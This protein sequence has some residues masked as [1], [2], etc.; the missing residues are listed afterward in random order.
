MYP[1]QSFPERNNAIPC[2]YKGINFRS[3]LEARWAY[4]FDK[5]GWA[6]EY[7]P[8]EMD[9][10]I[11]DFLIFTGLDYFVD[12][13]PYFNEEYRKS[14]FEKVVNWNKSHNVEKCCFHDVIF[15]L[16]SPMSRQHIKEN[17]PMCDLFNLGHLNTSFSSVILVPE[18]IGNM[19]A[20]SC[21]YDRIDRTKWYCGELINA[22]GYNFDTVYR[23]PHD[24]LILKKDYDLFIEKLRKYWAEAQNATQYK[25]KTPQQFII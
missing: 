15:C 10:Y 24:C 20:M 23:L 11:P 9:G 4:F 22:D 6:W 21:S 19:K 14:V 12:I 2:Q 1:N 13:K 8:F 25:P 18:H 3:L 17:L 5:L 16:S 7:E